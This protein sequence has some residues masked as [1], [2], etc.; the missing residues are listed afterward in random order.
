MPAVEQRRRIVRSDVLKFAASCVFVEKR[1]RLAARTIASSV[2][3]VVHL[4]RPVEPA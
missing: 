4:G 1:S 2:F 3:V